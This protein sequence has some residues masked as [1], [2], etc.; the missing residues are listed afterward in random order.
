MGTR[1]RKRPGPRLFVATINPAPGRSARPPGQGHP[2][3]GQPCSAM[4]GLR[5]AA[6]VATGDGYPSLGDFYTPDE[7]RLAQ[8]GASHAQGRAQ[9]SISF[10]PS[11]PR[12][13]RKCGPIPESP[14]PARARC[15]R[16]ARARAVRARGTA[17]GVRGAGSDRGAP[18]ISPSMCFAPRWS[19]TAP[20][21]H[22]LKVR[23]DKT[24]R[25]L[26]ASGPSPGWVST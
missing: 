11:R 24:I 1:S 19:E 25:G 18:S 13:N 10:R 3:R 5:R 23:A 6:G 17:R 4:A 22:R 26:S 14:R 9:A 8:R 12:S 7:T 15:D 21:R 2:P 16:C 20:W